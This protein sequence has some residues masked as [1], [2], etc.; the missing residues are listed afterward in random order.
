[1]SV[2]KIWKDPKKGEY[3]VISHEKDLGGFGIN[4]RFIGNNGEEEHLETIA[5]IYDAQPSLRQ[6][7]PVYLSKEDLLKILPL[8]GVKPEEIEKIKSKL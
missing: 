5:E 2:T 8:S 6:V 1:M 7:N 4:F 3:F